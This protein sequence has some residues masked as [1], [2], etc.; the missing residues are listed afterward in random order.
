MKRRG[1]EKLGKGRRIGAKDNNQ[2][3]EQQDGRS[4]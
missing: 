2:Y 3:N 4:E 1:K